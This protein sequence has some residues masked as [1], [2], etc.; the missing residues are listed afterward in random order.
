MLQ[1]LM[2]TWALHYGLVLLQESYKL[3]PD[4]SG[5]LSRI[6]QITNRILSFLNQSI[7]TWFVDVMILQPVLLWREILLEVSDSLLFK[8]RLPT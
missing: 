4:G 6:I 3:L 2:L 8:S 7:T 1:P 5:I